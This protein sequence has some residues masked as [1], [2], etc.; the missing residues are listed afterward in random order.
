MKKPTKT[1]RLQL[2]TQVVRALDDSSLTQVGGASNGK[3]CVLNQCSN[4]CLIIG[5]I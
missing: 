4:C 2:E 3:T 5:H 1:K